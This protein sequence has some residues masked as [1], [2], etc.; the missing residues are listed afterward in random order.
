MSGS[1][2]NP[3]DE[4]VLAAAQAILAVVQQAVQDPE[5]AA[6]IDSVVP[7]AVKEIFSGKN[8]GTMGAQNLLIHI[9]LKNPTWELSEKRFKRILK[10]NGIQTGEGGSSAED[11]KEANGAEANGNGHASSDKKKKKKKSSNKHAKDIF[12]PS[13]KVD[14]TLPLPSNV[15][16]HFFNSVKG[17]G[18]VA[19]RDFKEGEIIFTEDAY[20]PSPPAHVLKHVVEGELCDYC[21]LPINHPAAAAQSEKKAGLSGMMSVDCSHKKEGC[22]AK[23]C[24]RLCWQRAMV[25]HHPLLCA[26]A[27]PLIRQFLSIVL[28]LSWGAAY[29]SARALARV[30]LTHSNKPT[31]S[32]LE[33]KTSETNAASVAALSGAG[34]A[35]S[36]TNPIKPASA[37]EVLA[38]LNAF[39]TVDELAR[40][41]RTPAWQ[42]EEQ[43]F[44]HALSECH[45]ALAAALNPY[46]P[47]RE[48]IER[49][50]KQPLNTENAANIRIAK[51]IIA[52]YP[53]RPSFPQKLAEQIFHL[54]SWCK[55]LGRAN[56]NTENH[57]SLCE[58]SCRCDCKEG[59]Y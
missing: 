45:K 28:Q 43:Q 5:R 51:R 4:Q 22:Q 2:A 21:F 37:E 17:K 7:G 8:G 55:M 31:P 40:R 19:T 52:D 44:I 24:N 11:K 25:S 32:L 23:W 42:V 41:S 16:T 13:S 29:L 50:A 34:A 57:G 59:L 49:Q 47:E 33:A 35:S 10:A 54:D 36:A 3:S 56:I 48:D 14:S 18:L 6:Q 20:I 12:V 58:S 53:V 1:A 15:E 27:N 39:A 30:L 38:H 26:G 9:K 46:A